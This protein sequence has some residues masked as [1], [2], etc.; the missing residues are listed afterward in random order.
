MSCIRKLSPPAVSALVALGL[1]ALASFFF[2][3]PYTALGFLVI[4]GF[5]SILALVV[6]SF[7][8]RER[9]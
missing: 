5:G 4:L 8:Y 6:I 1:T 7:V 3:S 9:K 2:V